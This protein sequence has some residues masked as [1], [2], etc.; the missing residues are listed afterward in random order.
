MFNILPLLLLCVYPCRCFQRCLNR[1]RLRHQLLHTFMDA[2]QGHFK[3]GTNGTRDCRWFSAL[4]LI[5]RL[6]FLASLSTV[7]RYIFWVPIDA[8]T[9]LLLLLLTAILRPYKSPVHNNLDIFLLATLL[10]EF[11]G[12]MAQEIS[13]ALLQVLGLSNFILEISMIIPFAYIVALLLYKL[14][15]SIRCVRVTCR[16]IQANIP[17]HCCEEGEPDDE[18]TLPYRMVTAE[19]YAPLLGEAPAL[20]DYNSSSAVVEQSNELDSE[21]HSSY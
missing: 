8:S 19:E 16:R 5:V 15:S 20:Q 17:C 1:C 2:F 9:T 14:C 18:E 21:T 11:I 13:L 10:F 12:M 3:D 7:Y 4:Y 6:L